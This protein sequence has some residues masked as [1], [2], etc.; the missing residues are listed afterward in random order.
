MR[1]RDI[2]ISR[3]GSIRPIHEEG[4]T[5]ADKYPE[6]PEFKS[7]DATE[8]I[9][10]NQALGVSFLHP[11]SR[12]KRRRLER[13]RLRPSTAKAPPSLARP[14]IMPKPPGFEKEYI[15]T[16]FEEKK[17]HIKPVT[18]K[19]VSASKMPFGGAAMDG[20]PAVVKMGLLDRFF[21]WI[22]RLLERKP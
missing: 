5:V 18:G 1:Q 22:N 7:I 13:E 8:I 3:R 21:A 6:K 9:A 12:I 14:V 19:S 15:H 10:K 17:S 4:F 16:F 2:S 20:G 11:L